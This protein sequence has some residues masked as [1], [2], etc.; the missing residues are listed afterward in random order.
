MNKNKEITFKV[1]FIDN[2]LNET[3]KKLK[4][5][6]KSEFDLYNLIINGIEHIKEKPRDSIIV[7]KKQ[8]PKTYFKKYKINN[9]R[10]L[11]LNQNWRLTYTIVSDE[12]KII[13]IILEWLDHK[14]YEKRFNYKVK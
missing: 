12:V 13:S 9:L 6:T 5:G 2:S 8:I 11:K 4:N 10:I 1:K 7:K 14:N 3:L